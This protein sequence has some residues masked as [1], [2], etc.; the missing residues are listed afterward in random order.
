MPNSLDINEERRR[1]DDIAGDSWY[2]KG[3]NTAS[4]RY[5][6]VVLSRF[7]RGSRCLE[8]GPAEG[9]MTELLAGA[10]SHLTLVEGAEAF[11]KDLRRRFPRAEV[12]HA[13]F[14]NFDTDQQFDTIVLGHVL[15]HVDSPELIL[16]RIRKYLAP[17]GVICC[18]VPNARSLHRQAAVIMGL[19][20]HEHAMNDT[21]RHHGHRRV[22]DPESLRAE[23][24]SAGLKIRFFGGYW[25]KP[26]SN[27]QIDSSWTPE[28]INAFMQLGERYPDIAAE[29]CV[30][31]G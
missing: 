15:E 9:V 2:A 26:L 28:M 23:F 5:S 12:V 22:Y 19:L 20:P 11:C 17:E 30:V 16:R 4:V 13:L 3:V 14:E 7:W 10:F 29:I 31:A 27:A 6:A 21:D 25:I 24:L 18:A 1:L 8:L